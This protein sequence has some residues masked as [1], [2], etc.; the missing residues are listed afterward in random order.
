MYMLGI[1][2][3]STKKR[4]GLLIKAYFISSTAYANYLGVYLYM[5]RIILTELH[6]YSFNIYSFIPYFLNNYPNYP[7]TSAYGTT[8]PPLT[9]GL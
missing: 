1:S 8:S 4:Y 9:Y 3:L 6:Y 5:D 7:Y 2:V